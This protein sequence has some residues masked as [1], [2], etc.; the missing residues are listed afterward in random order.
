MIPYPY[1]SDNQQ[2]LNAKWLVDEKAAI[3]IEQ[4]DFNVQ[5][6]KEIVRPFIEDKSQLQ[7]MAL[8]ARRVGVRDAAQKIVQLFIKASHG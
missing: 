4:A 1:H 8:N 6:L 5:R 2:L 7:D 3:L